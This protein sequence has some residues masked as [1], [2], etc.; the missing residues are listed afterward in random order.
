MLLSLD[1]VPTGSC[2]SRSC[3]KMSNWV[4]ITYGLGVFQ[5][6][7]FCAESK[8]DWIFIWA[9]LE[10]DLHYLQFYDSPSLNLHWFS[11]QA[12]WEL[13]FLV[14]APRSRHPIWWTI[15]PI[16]P[17][18]RVLYLAIPKQSKCHLVGI[19]VFEKLV[20]CWEFQWRDNHF[21][22]GF[23]IH[24]DKDSGFVYNTI[25]TLAI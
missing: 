5:S 18:G 14:P 24:N 21:N 12:F 13:V 19:V 1:K 3:F 25:L 10:W 4:S 8:E 23:F 16:I 17:Q 11:N 2:L 20:S 15:P 9:L 7:L 22:L 6:V